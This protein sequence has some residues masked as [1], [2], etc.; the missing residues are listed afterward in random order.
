[1]AASFAVSVHVPWIKFTSVG[2]HQI[3]CFDEVIPR[4]DLIKHKYFII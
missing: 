1:M 2:V 3:S 4:F